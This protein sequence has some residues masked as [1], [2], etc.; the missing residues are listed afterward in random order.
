LTYTTLYTTGCDS[1][2]EYLSTQN[3]N[4]IEIFEPKKSIVNTNRNYILKFPISDIVTDYDTGNINA[5]IFPC[6]SHLNSMYEMELTD[7]NFKHGRDYCGIN[8]SGNLVYV[9]YYDN[10]DYNL[11]KTNR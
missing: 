9:K 4:P 11:T 8:S 2:G 7:N 10:C 5:E 3:D 1:Y 6:K